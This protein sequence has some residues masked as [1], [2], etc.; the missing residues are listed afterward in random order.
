MLIG[1]EL[2]KQVRVSFE[3]RVK[4][5][6]YEEKIALVIWASISQLELLE[7]DRNL[8]T[9]WRAAGIQ[10]QRFL[11]HALLVNLVDLK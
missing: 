3:V 2:Y 8:E 7:E 11:R 5:N 10:H 9:V 6:D 1:Y 4:M